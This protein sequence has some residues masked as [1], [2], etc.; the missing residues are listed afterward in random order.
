M[1]TVSMLIRQ[2]LKKEESKRGEKHG[3]EI[4]EKHII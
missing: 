2:Y 3:G 4:Y 1:P